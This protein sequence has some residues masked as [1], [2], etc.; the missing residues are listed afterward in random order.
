[1]TEF[2]NVKDNEV[3]TASTTT[4]T[5]KVPFCRLLQPDLLN[6]SESIMHKCLRGELLEF[7]LAID[8]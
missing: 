6:T 7:I 5:I 2:N 1:M 8:L 4:A 3:L